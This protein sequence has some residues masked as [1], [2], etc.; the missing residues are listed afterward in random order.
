MSA[1]SASPALDT[2]LARAQAWVE[3][4][5]E[6]WLI[7]CPDG[8]TKAITSAERLVVS[9][10]ILRKTGAGLLLATDLLWCAVDSRWQARR[11]K[12]VSVWKRSVQDDTGPVRGKPV[13]P[14]R[15]LK[16]RGFKDAFAD[17]LEAIRDKQLQVPTSWEHRAVFTLMAKGFLHISHLEGVYPEQVRR[18]TDVPRVQTLLIS[19]VQLANQHNQAKRQRKFSSG[20]ED[21]GAVSTLS[22]EQVASSLAAFA[23]ATGAWCPENGGP[24]KV[25]ASLQAMPAQAAQA[26]LQ[27]HAASLQLQSQSRSLPSVASGLRLWHAYAVTILNYVPE[28]SLPPQS[29]QDVVK[30]IALFRN[31]G[32]AANYISYL[33]WACVLHGLSL[34]WYTGQITMALKGLKKQSSDLVAG[35]LVQPNLLDERLV[36]QL[37]TLCD[38]LP[39]HSEVGTIFLLAWQFLL[40]GPSEAVPIEWGSEQ[41]LYSLP[42]GRHS[43]IWVNADGAT[44]LRLKRRKNRP[45]GSLLRR[46]CLCPA[47]PAVMCPGHRLL[48]SSSGWQP[49]Q[50]LCLL[51]PSQLLT[52]LHRLLAMLLVAAPE[53]YRWKGFRAGK[54]SCMAAAGKPLP[55]ILQAGEWRSAAMLA[56]VDPDILDAAAFLQE[57]SDDD[58]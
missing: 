33:K 27:D 32:T 12:L 18:W 42:P 58:E 1:A 17:L 34:Q 5:L 11:A 8:L 53:R 49:G 57:I 28:H 21:L 56:Y 54:A 13:C 48:A 41:E 3:A 38:S 24:A 23:P 20:R 29:S 26:A 50:R 44:S 36:L 51:T 10:P 14:F 25:L 9:K 30:F 52:K 37:M 40:R 6:T 16:P 19:A 4:T 45:Q 47:A 35:V 15:G 31:A 39:G 43:A 46:P 7:G 22:S 55:Q 2:Q